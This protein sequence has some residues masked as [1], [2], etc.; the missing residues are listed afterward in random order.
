V[1]IGILA[2]SGVRIDGTSPAGHARE[3]RSERI[4]ETP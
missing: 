4:T 1:L 3:A 2:V